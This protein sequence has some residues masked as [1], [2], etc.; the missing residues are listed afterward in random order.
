MAV[1][2]RVAVTGIGVVSPVGSDPDTFWKGLFEQPAAGHR[3]I[4]GWDSTPWMTRLE[5]RHSDRFAQF[6]VAAAEQAYA[7]AGAPEVDPD[8]AGVF[9]A[10]A[11]GGVATA[12]AQALVRQERGD[13]RVSPYVVPMMMPNAASAAVSL[14]RGW[15]GPCETIVTACAAATH[16]VGHAARLIADGSCDV[17][18]A[19]GAEAAL[20]PTVTAGFANMRALSMTG[21]LRPF[22]QERDGFV[23][24]EG[25]AVL[26]LESRD[27]AV[28]RGAHVYGSILGSASTADGHDL[29]APRPD[30]A[31][32]ARCIQAALRDAG[33]SA[34][35]VRQINAHGTGTRLNDHAEALAL[36]HVFGTAV[37]C[38]T[39]IKGATG[40]AFGASGAFEAAAVLLSMRHSLIPPTL[41]LRIIDAEI[42][43]PVAA[44][45][46]A[47]WSPGVAISNSF[48][49]GGHNGCL[50][51]GPPSSLNDPIPC[52]RRCAA[53]T[54][55]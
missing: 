2:R 33:I 1:G 30:G 13:R 44:G 42:N 11:L 51:V 8:R 50:V 34:D 32:A 52:H 26:M 43:F 24:S 7:D 55:D 19:G 6:A 23:I 40:H 25:A 17:A 41:G 38:V 49:F 22:D 15:R 46:G 18:L 5:E 14:R 4:V 45:D 27:W 20:T 10:T 3:H 28:S 12:E 16:A 37:P 47:P 39:S 29:T 21:V 36:H 53:Q 48:G 9:V 35:Q 54:H 31:Q